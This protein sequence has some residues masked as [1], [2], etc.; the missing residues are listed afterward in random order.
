MGDEERVDLHLTLE[1]ADADAREIDELTT[2]LRRELLEL[3]VHDVA[4]PQGAAPSGARGTATEIGQ[5][6]VTTA[7]V[8]LG[9]ILTTVQAWLARRRGG[10][11]TVE[12]P[13]GTK[14]ALDGAN[15]RQVDELLE[16]ARSQQPR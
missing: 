10:S 7:P 14:V 6:I 5:L 9:P 8:V 1:A 12:L 11:I 2:K 15:P 13:N 4:R 16:L 3:D